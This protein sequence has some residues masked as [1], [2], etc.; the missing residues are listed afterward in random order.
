M[1][2]IPELEVPL[3]KL[4]VEGSSPF[5]RSTNLERRA[6]VGAE[7]GNHAGRPYT[8][9]VHQLDSYCIADEVERREQQQISMAD[10]KSD[11]HGI[12]SGWKR[13]PGFRSA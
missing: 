5:A 10:A 2:S 7:T 11:E 8:D 13:E 3:P 6:G 4:N 12:Q 1:P 9:L